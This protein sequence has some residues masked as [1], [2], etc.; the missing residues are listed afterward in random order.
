[1][2]K[3]EVVCPPHVIRRSDRGLCVA[4]TGITL[5]TIMDF[6]KADWPEKLIRDVMELTDD[7]IKGVTDYI[8]SNRKEF[9]AEYEQVVKDAEAD[10]KFWEDRNRERFERI[11][12]TEPQPGREEL[13]R[14]AQN[15][16]AK[17]GM[18]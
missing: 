15:W 4:G 18:A 16:K 9:E 10:R 11:V 13:W 1:M 3:Q 6:I 14:L 7:Q 2:L 17:L 5:Y 8:K 12:N